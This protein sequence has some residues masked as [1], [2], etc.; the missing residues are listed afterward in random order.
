M[1]ML[2]LTDGTA[3]WW[4]RA[5][6]TDPYLLAFFLF[7]AFVFGCCI[8]S[9]LNV[10]IWRIPLGES[11]AD[12]PS[13]CP[14]CGYEIRWFDNIPL[15]SFLVLGCRC[16]HC[17]EPITWRYF[18]VEALTGT[19]F[20][21]LLLKTGMTEQ[22][23]T[24]LSVYWP[25]TMLA[26][27]TAWIDT[28]HR[29]IPDLTTYPA[30]LAGLIAAV[31]LPD[32]WSTESRVLSG[33]AALASALIAGG[34]LWAFRAFAMRLSG[35]EAIGLGDVK[36]LAAVGAL[37]GLPGA[38][39]VLLTGSLAGSIFGVT[40]AAV[41]HTPLKAK[42]IAFGP[43]LAGAAVIWMFAGEWMLRNYLTFCHYIK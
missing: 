11:I 1:L 6:F 2:R 14:K 28:E 25:M 4:V 34:F 32:I 17:R 43:F 24:M 33:F 19:L 8:G 10:C 3:M 15:V 37:L 22:P 12:A 9:F 13:H 38:F 39:F 23:V 29:I 30:L 20:S 40:A 41:N 36:F 16:R 35:K 5:G 18:I 26:V 21:L 27:T 31:A 42:A 7:S